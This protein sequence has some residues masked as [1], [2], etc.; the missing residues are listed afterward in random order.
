MIEIY[1]AWVDFGIDGFRIDTVKHVNIEFWQQFAHAD[2]GAGRGAT[3]TTTSSCSARCSTRTR[4]S[5]PGTRP[6]AAC[7]RRS[8]SASRPARPT[9]PRAARRRSCATSSP[10]DD[11]YTDAD[12]NAYS[13]PTFLGNHDMGRI[14]NF[15]SDGGASGDELLQ[16]DRLAHSLMYLSR[17]QPV[18]YYGDEQ[19]F[20]GDGGDQDARQDM[21]P[22]QVASYNDDDLIGTDATTADDNYDTDHPLYRC[23]AELVRAAPGHP[24][25]ADGAQIHRYA[26]DRAGHLRVQPH[27][28]R[29]AGRVRRGGEQQRAAADR[30]VRHVDATA[31]FQGVWPAGC[32]RRRAATPRAASRV[33]VPPL[34]A[35]RV[36]GH[37]AACERPA[38]RAGDVLPH[39]RPR[40]HRRR[41]GRDRR[42]GARATASTR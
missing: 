23:L 35:R 28:R 32:R 41:P 20:V 1:Q 19:G 4:R 9:S 15:L 13:L 5:C 36:A 30:D 12:S 33:T 22:S 25:L 38:A 6:R 37:V 21:F 11:Y 31:Q 40:R 26:S 39:A 7:R 27:R 17:G 34:S 18:V 10:S 14:G 16:R 3:A 24:A 29:R 8:T 2:R 42:G